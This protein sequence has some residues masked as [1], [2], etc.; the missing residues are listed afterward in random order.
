MDLKRKAEQGALVP[1]AKKSRQDVVAFGG[2]AV[3]S[4]LF[5]D[6]ERYSCL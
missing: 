1:A 5:E 3:S 4:I 2:D 6:S